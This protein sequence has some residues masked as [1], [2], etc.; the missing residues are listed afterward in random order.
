MLVTT[1]GSFRPESSRPF[2][3]VL[4]LIPI[5]TLRPLGFC[6]I[7][8]TEL[9]GM[10]LRAFVEAGF[11]VLPLRLSTRLYYSFF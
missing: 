4:V 9:D 11:R 6:T 1:L 5:T 2:D 8:L 7:G 3:D 10:G